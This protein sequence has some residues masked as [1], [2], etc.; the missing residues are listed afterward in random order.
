MAGSTT[1]RGYRRGVA[2][3]GQ[4]LTLW[5]NLADALWQVPGQRAE[6]TTGYRRAIGSAERELRSTPENP[7]VL[8]QVGYFD[9]RVENAA[10]SRERLDLAL[11]VAPQSP[12]VNYYVAIAAADAGDEDRAV[13]FARR[14]ME[15]G[16]PV[17]LLRADPG[18]GRHQLGHRGQRDG[19]ADRD[20]RASRGHNEKL[21]G[22]QT[23]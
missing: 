21:K 18:A 2:L 23:R 10:R 22:K 8:A 20:R 16:Y 11:R 19:A 5:G 7:I 3:T 1:R 17:V 9:G 15:A 4:N 12:F 14:S 6:A 13:T